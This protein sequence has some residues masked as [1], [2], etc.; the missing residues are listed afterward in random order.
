[1]LSQKSQ[2]AL[3]FFS[4]QL[5]NHCKKPGFGV[6]ASILMPPFAP[7]SRRL[8]RPSAAPEIRW[9][10][11]FS[12]ADGILGWSCR[13]CGGEGGHGH[14]GPSPPHP[15]TWLS[16]D[17]AGSGRIAWKDA[18]RHVPNTQP[19]TAL[20]YKCI[21]PRRLLYASEAI[22]WGI[23]PIFIVTLYIAWCWLG[24]QLPPS[25]PHPRRAT[26]SR[27]RHGGEHW[28]SIR[29]ASRPAKHLCLHG[30]ILGVSI[31]HLVMKSPFIYPNEA[32]CFLTA[33]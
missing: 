11:G 6:G 4:E 21:C 22:F 13:H 28:G 10:D 23:S 8:R 12:V 14:R 5:K 24:G 30:S 7:G 9:A 2:F 3:C 26:K 32:A 25:L 18:G 17:Q 15:G 27:C 29:S 20:P 33:R 16:R 19:P 31:H 1:M